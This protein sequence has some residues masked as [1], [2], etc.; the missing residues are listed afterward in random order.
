[1]RLR[2]GP[3]TRP[4]LLVVILAAAMA[5]AVL[6]IIAGADSA[7][8]APG[9]AGR[10]GAAGAAGGATAGDAGRYRSALTAIEPATP[11]LK[12]SVTDGGG[13]ITLENRTGRQVIVAG[14]AG[15]PYLRFTTGDVD[16]NAASLT[17]ALNAGLAP[18]RRQGA[19]E[20]AGVPAVWERVA[21]QPV[22]S[23]RDA[24]VRWSAA[25]RPPVVE[26]D[27][28]SRHRVFGWALP[29]TVDGRAI[30]VLGTV[31]WTGTPAVGPGLM[32]LWF[33][34]GLAGLAGLLAAGG[35]VAVL[36]R[37]RRRRHPGPADRIPGSR[38]AHGTARVAVIGMV[39]AGATGTL[40]VLTA[41]TGDHAAATTSGCRARVSI[42][43]AW[44]GGYQGSVT[45]LGG[46]AP[47]S[48]WLI[49]FALPAGTGLVNGWNADVTRS[50]TTVSAAAPGWNRTLATGQ[51]ASVGFVADGSG[52]PSPAS[53]RLNGVA[54]GAPGG[55]AHP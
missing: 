42:A 39:T 35:V 16:R 52:A 11:G 4:A 2:P 20:A 7:G 26:Q 51:E 34:A 19:A 14:Y 3:I 45:V 28:G 29:V 30:R 48:P 8:G 31:D 37:T 10:A 1:M 41:G 15:E 9:P 5:C 24:R 55:P 50:G 44:P 54:C 22:Y 46:G 40:G 27:E 36:L 18:T 21:D 13:P 53:I 25:E 17:A 38:R 43:N 12:V 49:T 32:A 6:A 23:W 33:P 47:A